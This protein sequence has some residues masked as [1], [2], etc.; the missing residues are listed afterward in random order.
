MDGTS[1]TSSAT[2]AAGDPSWRVVATGRENGEAAIIWQNTN[3]QA[4]IWLMNGATPVAEMGLPN[5]TAAWQ[6]IGTG[7][8]NNDGN[9]DLL[10]RNTAA[11]QSAIWLMNGTQVQAEKQ[12]QV[13][14][15]KN[16]DASTLAAAT[17]LSSAPVLVPGDALYPAGSGVAAAQ[18][19]GPGSLDQQPLT[20]P[21][22]AGIGS[23]QLTQA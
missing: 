15:S 1:V 10:F 13:S 21:T 23:L 5:P 8:F 3:G 4:G 11:H 18:L 6:I 19:A 16:A 17:Q 9:S 12:P 2:I 20:T 14:A 22:T 7:D